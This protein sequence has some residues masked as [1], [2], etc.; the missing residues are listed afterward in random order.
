M[1]KA[2]SLTAQVR[3]EALTGSDSLWIHQV[4]SPLLPY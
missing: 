1:E 4:V 2:G 3:M